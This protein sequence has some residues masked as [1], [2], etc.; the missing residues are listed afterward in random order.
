MQQ[1]QQQQQQQQRQQQLDFF[2]LADRDH[3]T[4][5]S[6]RICKSWRER[7]RWNKDL[8]PQTRAFPT[9]RQPSVNGSRPRP[10]TLSMPM[11]PQQYVPAGGGGCETHVPA[12]ARA[13]LESSTSIRTQKPLS[14]SCTFGAGSM[15]KVKPAYHNLTG[16][17]YRS[18]PLRAQLAIKIL[19]QAKIASPGMNVIAPTAEA[20][21]KQASKEAS[22]E[23]RT[24]RGRASKY[25]K[26]WWMLDYIITH[27]RL[28]ERVARKFSRR[29][30]SALGYC[31]R[32]N[33]VHRDL[34]IENI[35]MFQMGNIK[36]IDFA[37][38]TAEPCP[39]FYVCG[40]GGVVPGTAQHRLAPLKDLALVSK[41]RENGMSSTGPAALQTVATPWRV[42]GPLKKE[43]VTRI[44]A[45]ETA[46]AY[47]TAKELFTWGINNA[48]LG[49][50][51]VAAPVQVL[52]RRVAQI[53][54]PVRNV[55]LSDAAIAVL[56]TGNT[57]FFPTASFPPALTAY[58]P[59]AAQN[60]AAIAKVI[61]CE[62]AFAALSSNGE[63]F[64][65][66]FPARVWALRKQFSAVNDVAL[67][68]DGTIVL[69]TESGH[70]YIR[71]RLAK[72]AK[73]QRMPFLQRVVRVA[74]SSACAFAALRPNC[75]S[76][77]IEIVGN[78]LSKD[79]EKLYSHTCVG[80]PRNFSR[81]LRLDVLTS[82]L[83]FGPCLAMSTM[84]RTLRSFPQLSEHAV[85][86][87]TRQL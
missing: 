34:K 24:M 43:F 7:I 75:V 9:A 20:A 44:A 76:A 22:K 65:F 57:V 69:C 32:N 5:A 78:T 87:H 25:V 55:A 66:S 31:H 80:L 50:E 14:S 3:L 58:R 28:R 56:L 52:P 1:P 41:L 36:I 81:L 35:L 45:C 6:P 85:L 82:W 13:P 68:S 39:N 86:A 48:Q 23:T 8:S 59:P 17:K 83:R 2:A 18:R 4:L 71:K 19:P 33:V 49:Y 40:F 26:T 54:Q 10:R 38:V 67:G 15:V 11:A 84:P 61:C 16:K 42:V 47:W 77:P 60:N 62:N 30:G 73:F 64:T 21:A 29:K 70:M 37:A 79:M 27:G 53:A 74:A 63:I 46:S 72:T 12:A 51:T